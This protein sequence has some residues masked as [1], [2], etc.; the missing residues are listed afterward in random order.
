MI[1]SDFTVSPSCA[2]VINGVCYGPKLYLLNY[3]RKKTNEDNQSR[4]V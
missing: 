3:F 4:Y 2:E 1:I